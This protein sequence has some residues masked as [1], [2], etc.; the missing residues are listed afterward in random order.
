[1][2]DAATIE[3]APMP[4]ASPQAPSPSASYP[5]PSAVLRLGMPH[6]GA[7]GLCEGFALS[8][9]ADLH[10]A[11]IA[12]RAGVAISRLVDVT[13]ARALPSIV[14]A[15]VTGALGGFREDAFVRLDQ[16][17]APAPENGWRSVLR[18]RTVDGSACADVELVSRFARREGPSN[19]ALGPAEMPSALRAAPPE[20]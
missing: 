20:T 7:S 10:W 3:R 4:G 6:L 2:T 5:Q 1:M 9:A 17:E 14:A 19:A 12:R 18:I 8:T 16:V 11:S 15:R 13:G